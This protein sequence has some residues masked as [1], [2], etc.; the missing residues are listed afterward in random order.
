MPR[1]AH[2]RFTVRNLHCSDEVRA[3]SVDS[4]GARE[5]LSSIQKGCHRLRSRPKRA[6]ARLHYHGLVR[7]WPVK[8]RFPMC[9]PFQRRMS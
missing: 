9:S 7:N 6:L 2:E 4:V 8:L 3:S 1:E 5:S